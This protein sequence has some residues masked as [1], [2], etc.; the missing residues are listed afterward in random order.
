MQN[1]TKFIIEYNNQICECKFIKTF[2]TQ[3]YYILDIAGFGIQR[4]PYKRQL[5]F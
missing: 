2:G 4:I 1:L 3:C 5:H